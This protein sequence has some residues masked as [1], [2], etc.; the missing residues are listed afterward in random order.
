MIPIENTSIRHYFFIKYFFHLVFSF[1]INEDFSFA[2]KNQ[3]QY[4]KSPKFSLWAF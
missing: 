3:S 4:L 2:K 1:G